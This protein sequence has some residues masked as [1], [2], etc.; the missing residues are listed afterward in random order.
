LELRHI[1]Y[2]LAVADALNVSR[3]AEALGTAQPSLSQQIRQLEAEIGTPLFART[4]RR[5]TLTPA[6]TAFATEARAIVAGVETAVEHA[7]EAARGVR[8]ELRVVYT[9]TAM[10]AALPA[11]IRAFRGAFPNVR[12]TLQSAAAADLSDVLLGREADVAVYLSPRG[13]DRHEGLETRRLG[14]FPI[15]VVLP[16]GHR[17]AAKRSVAIEEFGTETLLLW[18]RR[19]SDI[20]DAVLVYARE[21]GF[22]PARIEEIDR[23]EAVLG[24]V[25]A[26]EGVSIIPRAY[27]ALGFRGVTYRPLSPAL[28]PFTMVV[29]R[30][31]DAG[32]RM[33]TAFAET[34]ARVVAETQAS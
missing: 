17:L 1:R 30:R 2:F 34:I 9:F 24:L 3:A 11:A 8:G 18:P 23:V 15:G 31:A 10:V 25:A 14:S 21:R 4:N 20:Y 6:G 28:A 27:E 12:I 26:G 29:A 32:S 13:V 16:E 33:I 19:L 5:M 22:T 7:R